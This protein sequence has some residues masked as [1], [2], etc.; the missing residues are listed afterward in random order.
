MTN[1]Q[2]IAGR[3]ASQQ[4]ASPQ[5]SDVGDLVDWMGAVQAQD[6]PG[7]LWGIGLR[8]GGCTQSAVED[9]IAQRKIIRS[10]PMRGTL[11]FTA[12][13]HL[14]WMLKYLTPRVI[15]RCASIYRRA[16]LDANTL[17]K[18][19]KLLLNALEGQKHL[20]RSEMYEV[21]ERAGIATRETRGLHILGYL[22]QQGLIC[23]G[24]RKGK[25]PTFVLLDEWLGPFPMIEKGEAFSRLCGIYFRSH[26][27]A[28]IDDF[29]WWSGLTKKEAEGALSENR[30]VISEAAMLGRKF[31]FVDGAGTSRKI[32]KVLLLPAW[33][34]Y[35]VAYHDR[36]AV[37]DAPG[38]RRSGFGLSPC[39]VIN[40]KIMGTWQRSFSKDRVI[41]TVKA[42]A[43][44]GLPEKKLI[45]SH[46]TRYGKFLQLEPVVK[47]N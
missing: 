28:L 18:S 22:A 23:F 1:K 32:P 36:T 40:G 26:G 15:S 41:V 30:G 7:S 34:E 4:L 3:L 5:F 20:T 12:P 11:H 19:E 42:F 35:T 6:Y 14:R 8:L 38:L 24:E 16:E 33:D 39:L 9:A 29:M 47:F 45:A 37:A 21:L 10:W 46:V 27:P 43:K 17:K 25:Q 44:P 31:Y 2:V 13:S